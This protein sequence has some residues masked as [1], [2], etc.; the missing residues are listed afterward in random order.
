MILIVVVSCNSNQIGESKKLLKAELNKDQEYDN[1]DYL[2]LK[3]FFVD[4]TTIGNKRKNKIEI[5]LYETKDSN[6]IRLNFYTLKWGKWFKKNKFEFEKDRYSRIDPK[7]SDFN[8]DSFLDFNYKATI[9]NGQRNDVRR[10]FIYDR[11]RDSL[12]LI[13]NSLKYPNIL[14]NKKLNCID[15][16][17][18]HGTSSQAFLKIKRD[19]L[20]D[21]AWIHIDNRIKVYEVNKNRKE[22]KILKN[23]GNKYGIVTRFISYNPL[24]EY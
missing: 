1:S 3:E 12:I 9:V 4:S 11:L 10:L 13:K 24:I 16:L 8:N 20:I 5:K 15:A 21:F 23:I 6:F 22:R 7:I 18:I 19:S 2:I 17:L 14:Y